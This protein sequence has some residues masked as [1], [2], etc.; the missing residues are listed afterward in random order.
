MKRRWSD[1][2]KQWGPFTF[3]WGRMGLGALIDSGHDEYPGCH[4]RIYGYWFTLLIDLP[5][6]I[7]PYR[8]CHWPAWDAETVERLGRDYYDQELERLLGHNS[9]NSPP[10]LE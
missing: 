3:A 5:Q 7:Q 8:E 9:N 2:Q 1:N 6:V 10:L 4:L